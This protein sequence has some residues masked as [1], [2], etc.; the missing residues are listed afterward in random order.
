MNVALKISLAAAL[1]MALSAAVLVACPLLQLP[2]LVFCA[3]L[4]IGFAAV[5]VAIVSTIIGIFIS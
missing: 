5:C 1:V 4:I 2:Y 3:T